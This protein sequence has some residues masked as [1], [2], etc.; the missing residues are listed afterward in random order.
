LDPFFY[1]ERYIYIIPTPQQ[2]KYISNATYIGRSIIS[3]RSQEKF[4][5]I[6]YDLNLP[7]LNLSFL[8]RA[9]F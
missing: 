7:R 4:G 8:N 6:E 9:I 1:D 3:R 5:T 2:Q